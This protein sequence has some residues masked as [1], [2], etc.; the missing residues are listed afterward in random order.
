MSLKH[1]PSSEP[2]H[3]SESWN[4]E[5]EAAAEGFGQQLG[6][7]PALHAGNSVH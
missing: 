4:L 7:R 1:E 2:L 5:D 6:N 3:I